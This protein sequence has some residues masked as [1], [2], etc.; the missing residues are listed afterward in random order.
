[1]HPPPVVDSTIL[2][3]LRRR[4]AW[5]LLGLDQPAGDLI[6]TLH[7][8]VFRW[9]QSQPPPALSEWQRRLVQVWRQNPRASANLA[10]DPVMETLGQS[11]RLDSGRNLDGW[12]SPTLFELARNRVQAD[13]LK[14]TLRESWQRLSL[15]VQSLRQGLGP[16]SNEGESALRAFLQCLQ[17]DI[18]GVRPIF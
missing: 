14:P 15:G 11:L 5:G 7:H 16:F 13:E 12:F 4:L 6:V 3:L 17:Q 18:L 8:F 9:T 2:E 10:L 1:M